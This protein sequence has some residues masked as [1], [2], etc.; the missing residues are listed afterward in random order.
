MK[1]NHWK[2][3]HPGFGSLKNASASNHDSSLELSEELET[4][5]DGIGADATFVSSSDSS[6]YTS[7]GMD[8]GATFLLFTT[9]DP[10]NHVSWSLHVNMDRKRLPK[11]HNLI[12]EPLGE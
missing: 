11:L 7:G 3:F 5:A 6:K 4:W 10:I 8:A 2:S 9:S 12:F 1:F